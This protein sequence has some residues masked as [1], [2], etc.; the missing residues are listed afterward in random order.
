[1]TQKL[2]ELVKCSSINPSVLSPPVSV[3]GGKS[4]MVWCSLQEL[5]CISAVTP[6]NAFSGLRS[7]IPPLHSE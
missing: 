4:A 6:K 3:G 1:M 7:P 2:F 5:P